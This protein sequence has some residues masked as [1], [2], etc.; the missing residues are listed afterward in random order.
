[1]DWAAV[2]AIS[3]AFTAIVIF[4]TA[5]YA[6]LQVRALNEQA[7]A[8]AEQI[9]HL[10][11]STQLA[12]MHEIFNQFITPEFTDAYSFVLTEFPERMKDETYRLE[13]ITRGTSRSAAHKEFVICRTF[14]SIGTCVKFGMIEGEPLYDFAGPTIIESWKALSDTI[15]A[16]RKAWNIPAQWENFEMLYR[17]AGRRGV[18]KII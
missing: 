13:T 10:R 16:Q 5:I 15:E 3:T 2:G 1:M 17:N 12:G 9:E 11:K 18:E 6:A 14:E 7:K 8:T 4:A